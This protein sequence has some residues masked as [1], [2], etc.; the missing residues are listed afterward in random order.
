M[1]S[2]SSNELI[3]KHQYRD[4]KFWYLMDSEYYLLEVHGCWDKTKFAGA[5]F[6]IFIPPA[7]HNTIYTSHHFY[8]METN[9]KI[10]ALKLLFQRHKG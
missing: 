10:V 8:V 9:C 6:T 2:R 1:S 3:N 7:F 5:L 4:Y